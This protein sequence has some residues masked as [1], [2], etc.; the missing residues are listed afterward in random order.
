MLDGD[1][2][3]R[4]EVALGEALPRWGLDPALRL[5]RLSVSENATF[6]ARDTGQ[7][8]LV[9]RVH[10]PGY[11]DRDEIASELAWL[12]AL[13]Q[14]D[15]VPAPRPVPFR[16]GHLI[17]DLE[18]GADIRHV[19]MFRYLPGEEPAPGDDLAR[20]FETL[21]AMT[22]RLHAHSRRWQRPAGFRR[23]VWNFE[24]MLGAR[25]L[26]GDWRDSLGLDAAG[27]AVLARTV[28]RVRERLGEVGEGPERFGLIHADL[29][30]ANLLVDGDRLSLIDFDDSGFC[31]FL[32]DF[33]AAISF[34]EHEPYVP[35]LERAWIAGY[36]TLAPLP[37][38]EAG[39]VPLFVIL[40]R[41]L[42]T[43]WVASHAETPTAQGLGPAYTAGTIA[44]CEDFLRKGG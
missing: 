41:I 37:E 14:E 25:P 31:W 18:D 33:A 44:L 40:R 4:I 34:I 8:D 26:W 21:G 29:R 7:G 6:L 19:V 1:F 17:A 16:D 12:A 13:A 30:L 11:H 2:L 28:A 20:W 15:V 32:Y 27:L 38:E 35:E 24:T 42:L 22:A 23:K 3:A 10:R 36:R 43:A 39:L 9:V 5:E